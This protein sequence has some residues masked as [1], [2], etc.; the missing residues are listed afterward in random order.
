VDMG[1]NPAA[2][3][4]SSENKMKS[5]FQTSLVDLEEDYDFNVPP[6]SMLEPGGP[7]QV[8]FSI[9]LRNIFQVRES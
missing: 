1:S 3:R 6:Q 7:L 8:N 2:G 5:S 9:N 4:D